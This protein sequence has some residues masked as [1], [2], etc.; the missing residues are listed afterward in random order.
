MEFEISSALIYL[1]IFL[2]TAKLGEILAAKLGQPGVFGDIIVGILIGPSVAGLLSQ[3]LLG[4]SLYINPNTP[5][6]QFMSVLG[7]IGI[8]IL[9]FIVGL[10]VDVDEFKRSGKPASVVAASGI[11]VAFSLGFIAASIFGW[12]SLEAAFAGGVLVATS[13]GITVRVLIEIKSLH[14]PVGMTILGAAVIDDVFGIIILSVLAGLAYGNISLFGMAETLAFMG[15]F[16]IVVLFVGF[17]VVSHV[18]T[19]IG[20]FRGDEIVLSTTLAIVFFVAAL[21]E[22]VGVAALT[23]AFLVGLIVSKAPVAESI[24]MKAS[25][26]G[27]GF[28]IPLFFVE[29]GVKTE[30]QVLGSVSI[31]ALAFLGIAVL[32]KIGGCGLGALLSG[33]GLKDSLRVG[34]G[35]MPRAEVALVIAAVGIKTGLVSQSLLPMTVMVV[36]VTSLITPLLVNLTFKGAH[37]E[38]Q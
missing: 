31:L 10:S 15:T 26:V 28:F 23:A 25:T 32:V 11:V 5:A 4:T 38:N 20:R 3:Q 24:R 16:F 6:G 8:I 29:I 21:A 33:F 18:L 14:A 22:R 19:Y 34:I 12:T 36:L 27:Y 7:E 17:R 30:L 13:V 9:L 35:M 37:S 2:V 1:A